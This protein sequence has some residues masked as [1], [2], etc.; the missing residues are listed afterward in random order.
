MDRQA[1]NVEVTMGTKIE[2]RKDFMSAWL[3]SKTVRRETGEE[4]GTGCWMG[5]FR[6]I[7]ILRV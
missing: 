5:F 6:D 4:V 3:K 1:F 7:N 2:V